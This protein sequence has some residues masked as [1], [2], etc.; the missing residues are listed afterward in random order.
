MR[1][2]ALLPHIVLKDVSGRNPQRKC[3]ELMRKLQFP[4]PPQC[5]PPD[6]GGAALPAA[7]SLGGSCPLPVVGGTRVADSTEMSM[8]VSKLDSKSKSSGYIRAQIER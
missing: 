5:G 3:A 4:S 8:F 6:T 2:S 1:H 7:A